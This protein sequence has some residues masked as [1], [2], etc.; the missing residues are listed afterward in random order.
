M[1]GTKRGREIPLLILFGRDM[2]TVVQVHQPHWVS[3]VKEGLGNEKEGKS[4][5]KDQ[6]AQAC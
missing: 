3:G 5:K 1:Y 2:Y 6:T 4:G